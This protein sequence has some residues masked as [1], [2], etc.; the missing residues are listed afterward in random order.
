MTELRIVIEES[1][2]KAFA[3]ALDWPGWSRSA[4]TGDA[5]VEA[6][7]AYADRYRPVVERAGLTPR[8]PHE[9][10]IVDR[11]PGDATT[12]FGAPG[13]VHAIEHAPLEGD[14]LERQVALLSA[15]WDTFF[16][17]AGRVTPELRKG[18]RGGGRDRDAIVA[19]V[20][21]VDRN[22]A[23]HLGVTTKPFSLDPLDR[24]AFDAHWQAVL[25]MIPE[26][27]DGHTRTEKGWPLRYTIR[28]MA[29][30]ILD[31]AWE[32]EDKTLG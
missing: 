27:A 31:H 5:A 20:V 21:E 1:P 18:P 10:E 25:A 30:H 11:Q 13:H 19:H 12:E 6:L 23:R 28:R 22:Y 2:K 17:V 32:K 3:S 24:G 26:Y 8:L 7:L 9:V 15:S 4:K 29:W 14:D 16:A